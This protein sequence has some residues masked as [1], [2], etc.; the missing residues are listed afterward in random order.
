MS[1]VADHPF[2]ERI[3]RLLHL[4]GDQLT[5]LAINVDSE[6]AVTVVT[7]HQLDTDQQETL[8]TEMA[9]YDVLLLERTAGGDDTPDR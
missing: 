4:D 5:W 9:V 1:S 2:G 7:E 8:L 6:G 3:C